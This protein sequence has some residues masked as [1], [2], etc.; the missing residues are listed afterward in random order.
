MH[1]EVLTHDPLGA[2]LRRHPRRG[3]LRR[4]NRPSAGA[5]VRGMWAQA[6]VAAGGLR[7]GHIQ[8]SSGFREG[9]DERKQS[10]T[11]PDLWAHQLRDGEPVEEQVLHRKQGIPHW[12]C[13]VLR[14]PSGD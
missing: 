6:G 12:L 14:C 13:W 8:E 4:G 3:G 1:R 9:P 2:V 11:T 5:R 10:R 7:S